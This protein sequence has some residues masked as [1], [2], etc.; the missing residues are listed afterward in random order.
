MK[1]FIEYVHIQNFK[2]IADLRLEDCRWINLFIGYPNVGKSNVLEAL[3]L[4][5][6]PHLMYTDEIHKLVRFEH[7]KELLDKGSASSFSIETN[8]HSIFF[9][10]LVD[11]LEGTLSTWK[12]Q[13]NVFKYDFHLGI[14]WQTTK[15]KEILSPPFG[16][17]LFEPLLYNHN[18][19]EVN[20]FFIVTHSPFI[21]DT[22]LAYE[23]LRRET[24]IYLF[25]YKNDQTAVKRLTDEEM[26]EVCNYGMDLFFNIESFLRDE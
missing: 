6:V 9:C 5:S 10:D 7:E 23:H 26:D 19:K 20:Q 13:S 22:F 18:T 16:E 3:G 2:S 11:D 14:E 1:N 8:Q 17:N 25:D 15:K 12:W 24:S 4:F 21:L